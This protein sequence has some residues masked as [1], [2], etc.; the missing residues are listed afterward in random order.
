VSTSSAPFQLF[1][2]GVFIVNQEKAKS[3]D[4]GH[5]GAISI[6]NEFAPTI[7]KKATASVR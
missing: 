5:V 3:P 4:Q 7:K 6:A 1:F 2:F